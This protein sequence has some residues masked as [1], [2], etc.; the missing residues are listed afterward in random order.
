MRRRSK[1][2]AD[3]YILPLAVAAVLL[4]LIISSAPKRGVMVIPEIEYHAHADFKVFVNGDEIDFSLPQ[5]NVRNRYIHLHTDNDFGG[6]VIHVENRES[7]MGEFFSSLGMKFSSTCFVEFCAAGG[8]T[9]KFYVNGLSSRDFE[10]YTPKDID[11]ILISYG[12]ETELQNQL[13]S[14]TKL[15]CAFSNKCPIP[16]DVRIVTL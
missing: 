3:K 2:N 14:I 1:A 16:S 9:L 13:N 7:T 6:S 11:R 12:N 15:A 5:Y 8:N 10:N 4:F